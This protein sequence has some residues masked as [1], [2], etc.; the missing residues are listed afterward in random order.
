MGAINWDAV[1]AMAEII[2][3]ITVVGSLI[4]IGF[5]MRQNTKALNMN[6]THGIQEA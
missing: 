5:Q 2:G 6:S 1:S 4:F 3:V